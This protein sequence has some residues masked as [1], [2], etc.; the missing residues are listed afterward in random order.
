LI[1]SI[2]DAPLGVVVTLESEFDDPSVELNVLPPNYRSCWL[3]GW[4]DMMKFRAGG[5]AIEDPS[6]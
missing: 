2:A 5:T 3:A 4:G 6:G 1:T